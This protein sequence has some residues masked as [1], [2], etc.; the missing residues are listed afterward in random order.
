MPIVVPDDAS[1]LYSVGS[2][3]MLSMYILLH[4]VYPRY[5]MTASNFCGL[6]DVLLC[7]LK[8]LCHKVFSLN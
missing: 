6:V 7:V 1:A 5:D 8:T 3:L 2:V 4:I